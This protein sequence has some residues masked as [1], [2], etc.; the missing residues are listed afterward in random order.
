[1]ERDIAHFASA[2]LQG[3]WSA[4]DFGKYL[5][6]DNLVLLLPKFDKLDPLVRVRLLL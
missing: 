2:K 1:M 5:N 4:S 6:R 3:G